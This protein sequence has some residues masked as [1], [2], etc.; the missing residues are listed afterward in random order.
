MKI[1]VCSDLHLEFGN[2][3]LKNTENAEVL[4][5]SGD[6]CVAQKFHD[7]KSYL[8]FFEQVCGEFNYVLYVMG[9]HEHYHGDFATSKETL[10]K[11]LS[12]IKN[13]IILEKETF[14]LGEYTFV[15]GTLWTD[16]N[17]GDE[18]T[19]YHVRRCMNDFRCVENSN[20]VLTRKVPLY[21]KGEDGK[22]VIG[23]NDSYIQIGEKFKEYSATLTPEDVLNDHKK[24]LKYLETVLKK[25]GKFIVVG[26][27]A[28][29]K[30]STH[31][32]Y[33]NDTLM[34][35]GYSSSLD[36]FIE[37]HPEIL[38]WTHGHTHETFDYKIGTT[39]VICNPRG[40]INYENRAEEFQL[41]FIDV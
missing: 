34:N 20:Q 5:L 27:H 25:D 18:P 36:F 26:H 8:D 35:G 10:Q 14:R 30:L 39:R 31:P 11:H 17:G 4:I 37:D 1:A 15:G 12:H 13:L 16:M 3:E 21:Q 2:I 9:N 32:R 28:P 6:I 7:N 22:Y 38:L 41:R 19:M 23:E 40:Y 29:S 33:Q 24:F